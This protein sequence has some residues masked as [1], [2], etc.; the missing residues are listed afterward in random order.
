MPWPLAAVFDFDG[1]LISTAAC[2][3]RAY[4]DALARAG[5]QLDPASAA[6]LTGASVQAAA[7]FLQVAVGDLRDSLDEAF[8][9]SSLPLL[10]GARSLVT[11]LAERMPLAVATNGPG[12]L[13][14]G[15]LE[16][17]GLRHHF[18][19]VLSGEPPRRA[20]PAPDVYTAACQV[21]G[22]QPAQAVAFE[23]S[24]VGVL[25]ARR[26]GL[27]VVHV[28]PPGEP[29]GADC[30]VPHLEDPR[31]LDLLGLRPASS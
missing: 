22:V 28:S 26:A 25:A 6:E 11:L 29:A 9:D 31:L 4:R 27:T 20:K 16:R 14:E 17:V 7:A 30:H 24:P 15:A 23:D 18:K 8:A 2:W 3:H 13:V 19:I 10:P 1:L 21:L 12:D 5:R